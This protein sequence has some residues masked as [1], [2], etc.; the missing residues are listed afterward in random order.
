VY[1]EDPEAEEL[2]GSR[3][4]LTRRCPT[5]AKTRRLVESGRSFG[6]LLDLELVSVLGVLEEGS[7]DVVLSFFDLPPSST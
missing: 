3:M 5:V 1:L 4:S 6:N 2:V 7:T